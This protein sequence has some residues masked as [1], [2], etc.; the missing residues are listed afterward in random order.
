MEVKNLLIIPDVE[1]IEEC[2]M[3]A[4]Q[5]DCGFE[6]N[7]FFIPDLLDDREYI[8]ARIKLYKSI[9]ELPKYCTFHGAFLDVTVFSDD[10]RI[11]QVSDYRV[12]QSL[13]L[14]EEIGANAVIFHTN[15]IP[16]FTLASYRQSWIDRNM[17]YW[18][19]KAE[20]HKNL[21]IYIENMFDTDW[22]LLAELAGNM[23]D[24][25]N[26]GVC[27]DYAHA[28]VF[29][30]EWEIDSWSS[31]LSPYVK[32]LHLNDNDYKDDLHLALGDGNIDWQHF[33]ENYLKY[34]S[35]ASVLLETRN[36]ERIKKSLEFINKL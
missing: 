9:D 18:R 6:Y 10:S 35:D 5:Y 4:R 26:F 16:N 36:M 15:Y 13:M 28:H 1:R 21:N 22:K 29:G 19:N 33:K 25:G 30:N 7:D 20:K 24:T 31:A 23:R 27:F 3:L 2:L 34:F 17:I 32:H 12:E 14:A 11:R 8:E